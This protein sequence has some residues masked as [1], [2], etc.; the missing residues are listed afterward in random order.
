MLYQLSHINLAIQTKLHCIL[1]HIFGLTMYT[2]VYNTCLGTIIHIGYTCS[3]PNSVYQVQ[4][5][6]NGTYTHVIH[7]C[8]T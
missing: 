4:L 3:T 6:Y 2:L 1:V 7:T 8:I 5:K